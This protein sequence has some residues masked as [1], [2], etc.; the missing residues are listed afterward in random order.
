M[1]LISGGTV[2]TLGDRNTIYDG[3]A[4][5]IDGDTIADVGTLA[6]LRSRQQQHGLQDLDSVPR[7]DAAG[8]VVMPGLVCAHHHLYSTFA[9]GMPMPGFAPTDFVGILSGLW[10]K[11]D[12]LLE[13]GDVRL[14]ALPVL[15]EGLRA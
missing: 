2:V 6:E 4:V 5:L 3:G 11:L 13:P 8:H 9:R 10:W 15:M 12:L 14:S 1:L 7:V